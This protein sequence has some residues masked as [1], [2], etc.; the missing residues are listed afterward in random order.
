MS[1]LTKGWANVFTGD[2]PMKILIADDHELFR[3]GLR[4][5]VGKIRDGTHVG[6]VLFLALFLNGQQPN[7]EANAG[8]SQNHNDNF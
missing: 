3:D 2:K 4:H 6:G 8:E 5:L 7:E 1:E